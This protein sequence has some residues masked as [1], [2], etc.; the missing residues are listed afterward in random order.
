MESLEFLDLVWGE[1]KGY[2]F[3]PYKGS[4]WVETKAFNWPADRDKVQ[5]HIERHGQDK[6]LYYCPNLFSKPERRKEF[7]KPLRW[8]YADLDSADPRKIDLK[9]TIAVQS[10]PGRHQGLWRLAR[11]LAPEKHEAYNRRLTYAVRADKGGWDLTQVLRIPGSRNHKYP[12]HIRV[13]LRW[14]DPSKYTL[15]KVKSFLEG[16][17]DNL[18]DLHIPETAD[19]LLPAESS[20][21]IRKRVWKSLDQRA[22]QLLR[23]TD[24]SGRDRSATL[25]ELECRLL[26]AGLVPEEVFVVVRDCVWN[27]YKGRRDSD[28]QLWREVQKAHLHTGS[29][30]VASVAPGDNGPARTRPRLLS[31]AELLG[32]SIR[33]PEW[34][35]EDWWTLGS[36]GIVAGLPKSYKSLVMFD[37]AVSLASET[38][39]LGSFAVNPR[40]VGPTL[41]VQ[42]ENS[43]PIVRDRLLKISHSRG[44]QIGK[45]EVEDKNTIV[46]QAPPSI[47]ILFY[48]DFG[49]DMTMPD[50]QEAIE[51]V[52]R[53]E[54]VKTV[55]F[56]P[57]YLMIG[58][59]DENS[60]R[61]MRPILQWLLRI[62]NLY[63]C[64][65]VVLHHWGK[66][67]PGRGGRGVGGI[68]LL[69]STTIYGW[70]EA[71][72]YLEA[73]RS[74]HGVQV[75][76]ERE[77][78]ERP[79]P[80]PIAFNLT[81]GDIGSTEYEWSKTGAI[82]TTN[83]LI[84]TIGEAGPRGATHAWI[85]SEMDWGQKKAR[86]ELDLIIDQGL[87]EERQDGR[88]KR[89][90]LTGAAYEESTTNT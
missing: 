29:I 39:F 47:P 8:L 76:V 58:G 56:D 82:G 14:S 79:S 66:G 12:G 22:R 43:L 21:V 70:L 44:L 10:S 81:I 6:D 73:N 15:V 31:Y 69:G 32:S 45:S 67:T 62:R 24:T 37:M 63:N 35:I 38:P 74:E 64:A 52:I 9:P 65:V 68:R 19:L 30:V 77:F 33:E 41:V 87:A 61:E 59:A 3:L 11:P 28:I 23:T 71:A 26:E 84:K 42:Q 2:V 16:V 75:V 48:N 40:A 57:L 53:Q 1:D 7:V 78:R 17:E 13:R 89:I 20:E 25:W 27:K 83:T 86:K 80:P 4:R 51:T 72:L 46:F 90:Y 50:D 5:R 34:A 55:M 36:H 60:A 49:F 54:G 18:A 88:S 85:R